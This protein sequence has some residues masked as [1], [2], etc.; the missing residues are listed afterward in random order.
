LFITSDNESLSGKENVAF[1]DHTKNYDQLYSDLKLGAF[2]EAGKTHFRIFAPD[3]EKVFLCVFDNPS[4]NSYQ[5]YGMI[6]LRDYV[7]EII[8]NGELYNKFYGFKV[9]RKHQNEI[10]PDLICLDPYSKAVATEIDYMGRKL[11]LIVHDN[12]NWES[13][14]WVQN[15]WRDL[16][17]YEAHIKDLTA[18]KSSGAKNPGTYKGMIE[19]GIKGGLNH[20]KNLGVNCVELLPAMEFTHLELPYK[21]ELN[22]RYNTWNPYEKNHWG[23]MTTSFFAP[24]A[25]FTEEGNKAEFKN[26]IGTAGNQ[27]TSFK[28]MVKA[29]HKENIAV[30]MDVVYNHLSEYEKANLKEI[31]AD[32]YFRKNEDGTFSNQSGCGND[33]KT[34][35]PMVRKMIRDSILH[36]MNEYHIDGFRFD[37]GHLI[38]WE[39]IEEVTHEARKINPHVVFMGEPWGGGYDPRGFSARD[40]ASWNDQIRNGIKGENPYNGKGWIF[41]NWYGNNNPS[42]I[43]SYVR[44][45]LNKDHH[46]LFNKKEH[47]VNYLESHDGYTLGDFIRIGLGDVDPHLPVKDLANHYKLT[48]KQLRLNKLAAAFLLTSQGIVM[49][50]SGQEFARSKVIAASNKMDDPQKGFLD[51]N[52]YNKD[53]ETNYINYEHLDINKNLFNYYQGLIRLRKEYSAFRHA[54]YEDILFQEDPHNHFAFGISI[55]RNTQEFL[56]L[57]NASQTISSKFSLPEGSWEILVTPDNVILSNPKQAEALITLEPVT[58]YILKRK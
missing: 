54:H 5:S 30:I 42:R 48:E 20:I 49:I 43:K 23:Y 40:C 50:H 55:Y 52:S 45:T 9:Q 58:S 1:S 25:F 2:V 44:G 13:D 11:S 28:E 18:H 35:R 51:H 47:S 56:V 10:N 16:I 39:T 33:L 53:D 7:W 38:D 6:R 22:R 21:Q 24:T 19:K 36:W 34:E 12:F 41:E 3:A 31:N 46:G 32:Y 27:V 4:D 37:L 57:F 8:L 14:T 15:D 26:W 17:I 29:F